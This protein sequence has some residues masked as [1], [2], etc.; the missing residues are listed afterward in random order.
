MYKKIAAGLIAFL[1]GIS[2]IFYEQSKA[3]KILQ[4]QIKVQKFQQQLAEIKRKKII[5]HKDTNRLLSVTSAD[6]LKA[7]IN[8]ISTCKNIKL[9]VNST[10]FEIVLDA[11]REKRIINFL[12]DLYLNTDGLLK[13]R[14]VKIMRIQ[15]NLRA[16]ICGQWCNVRISA[17][18]ITIQSKKISP[19]KTSLFKIKPSNKVL[20]VILGKQAF[21]NE[22]WYNI[23]EKISGYTLAQIGEYEVQLKDDNEVLKIR[24]GE[25]W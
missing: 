18:D 12:C 3:D 21:I 8:K 16:Q 2:F 17:N 6:K 7:Q 9:E 13:F 5:I 22:R 4:N 1:L 24:L 11:D 23:G 15:N 19:P 20:A 14:S 10:D 25:M